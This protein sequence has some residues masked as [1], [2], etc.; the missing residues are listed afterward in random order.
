MKS[1]YSPPS[2]LEPAAADEPTSQTRFMK[3][4]AR[5]TLLMGLLLVAGFCLATIMLI[6]Q[7]MGYQAELSQL[8]PP[9]RESA[10]NIVRASWIL[11]S[12]SALLM[13][14]S[15]A[16]VACVWLRRLS[17]AWSLLLLSGLLF[18]TLSIVFKPI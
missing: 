3:W 11:G 14:I 1:P 9:I 13:L 5:A 12:A 18:A 8:P 7:A 2:T 10:V 4:A 17:L 16:A 15:A 6:R